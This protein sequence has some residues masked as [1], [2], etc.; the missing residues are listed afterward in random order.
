[1]QVWDDIINLLKAP[2]VGDVDI[3]HLF[4]LIGVVLVFILIWSMILNHIKIAA[5]AL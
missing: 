1:M 4:L 3:M 5:E 2:F